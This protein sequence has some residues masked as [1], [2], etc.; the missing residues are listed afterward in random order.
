MSKRSRRTAPGDTS[1][2]G[3]G[4][5][6]GAPRTGS[7]PSRA[8]GSAGPASGGSAGG[9]GRGSSAATGTGIP[10]GTGESSATSGDRPAAT[11]PVPGAFGNRRAVRDGSFSPI[12][13]PRAGRRR[14]AVVQRHSF[15]ERFRNQ[16]IWGGI[17]GA[18]VII[19]GFVLLSSSTAA[20]ACS[21]QLDPASAAPSASIV[22]QPED[23]MAR[24]H[25]AV[26]TPVT[27]TYCPP[28]SGKHYNAA[29][30]GPIAPRFYGP[31]DT[32]VPQ[33]WIHNLEHGGLV[34]LY[35]CARSGCDTTSLDQLRQLTAT[36]PTSPRCNIA[37]G[38]LSPVVTRFDTMKSS[39]A[40]VLWNR[41]LFMDTLDTQK[42]LEFFKNVA[43]T[44]NP[45][46]QCNPSGSPTVSSGPAA[47]DATNPAANPA[48]SGS[49]NP[50][51]SSEPSASAV[52]SST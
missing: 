27:Y 45:E 23:D 12:G 38:L 17:I 30:Q 15:F 39:F 46:P 18:V 33:A 40:A 19:A 20:Y 16:L 2:P 49:A 1:R 8:A 5:G 52:P 48:E 4:T 7:G 21:I 36:F 6:A 24:G 51:G 41:V 42:I 9:A 11:G 22:G 10:T 28:A 50:A 32:T 29:G 25:V 44:E 43:E 26:G 37:G 35:N 13:T 31:D 34:I 14:D 3:P 47:P